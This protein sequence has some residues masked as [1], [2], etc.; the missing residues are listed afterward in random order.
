MNKKT[1]PSSTISNENQWGAEAVLVKDKWLSFDVIKKIRNPKEY[2]IAQIDQELRSSRTISESRLIIEAKKI[3]V[4]T[5][6]IYEIDIPN[7]TIIM[8]EIEG[9]LVKDILKQQIPLNEKQELAKNIGQQVGKL[10]SNDII[11]GDLTTSNMVQDEDGVIIFIDFGLGKFSKAIED[12]AVDILLMK[13]CF[14]STHTKNSD[15]LFASFQRGYYNTME[16]AKSVLKRAVKVEAR[17]RH[18]K[19]EELIN[20]YLLS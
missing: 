12:K 9:E 17:G 6:Y 10:H 1:I 7:T 2:R 8:E 3:G 13:K 16:K 14:I 15:E 4:R 18:L 20:E 11:H 5:P 19:E